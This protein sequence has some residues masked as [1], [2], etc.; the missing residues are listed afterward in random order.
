MTQPVSQL[1]N[2]PLSELQSVT[3][4]NAALQKPIVLVNGDSGTGKTHF[5][6]TC[7]EPIVI[8]FTDKNRQTALE[9]ILSGRKAE[10][11]EI[12]CWSDWADVFVPAVEN[13]MVK[14]ETIGLDTM[15]MLTS[16]MWREIQEHRPKLRIQDFG[17]GKDRMVNTIT[18][19]A[20]AAA[21]IEGKPSYNIVVTSHITDVTDDDT[22]A[23]VKFAPA[24]MGAF[25]HVAGDLFDYHFLSD[26]ELK[27]DIIE[28]KA[29]KSK[30]FFMHTIPPTRFH[31]TKAPGYFPA[32]I[33]NTWQAL[34]DALALN[35]ARKAETDD[36][37]QEVSK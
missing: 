20:S 30:R 11:R 26:S 33:N 13:R 15:D 9:A 21:H 25:K 36:N 37:N 12:T 18:Q 34:Q 1:N 10:L 3:A 27:T 24:V 19:F 5:L 23:L 35:P 8:A 6:M 17:T 29:I 31:R 22:G 2:D 14:A 4:E 32:E 16:I 7:P 28:G